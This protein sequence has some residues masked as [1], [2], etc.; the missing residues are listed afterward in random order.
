MAAA[1][2]AT[3]HEASPLFFNAPVHACSRTEH[4]GYAVLSLPSNSHNPHNY[5][6]AYDCGYDLWLHHSALLPASSY[7][8]RSDTDEDEDEDDA[9]ERRWCRISPH[10][11]VLLPA[12]QPAADDAAHA[13]R[14]RGVQCCLSF[15]TAFQTDIQDTTDQEMLALL[16][17]LDYRRVM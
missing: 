14:V 8:D 10:V 13:P 5:E 12:P 4:G 15:V 6:D 17:A 9:V 16:R 3:G 1:T 11:I 7:Y 2:F